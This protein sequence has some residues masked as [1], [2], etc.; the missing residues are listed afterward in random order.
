MKTRVEDITIG[1]ESPCQ[2]DGHR[3]T[4]IWFTRKSGYNIEC[5]CEKWWFVT[6]TGRCY[7][8]EK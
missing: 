1:G 5:S 2:K 4:R 8:K 3:I 7:P 6:V